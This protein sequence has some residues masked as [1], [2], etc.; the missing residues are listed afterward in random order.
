MCGNFMQFYC[1]ALQV[2]CSHFQCYENGTKRSIYKVL[3]N[4]IC[5]FRLIIKL[6]MTVL[7]RLSNIQKVNMIMVLYPYLLYSSFGI[8]TTSH[9]TWIILS[10]PLEY[11]S[12][13]FFL[14]ALI[15]LKFLK[16][17]DKIRFG[18]EKSFEKV[19]FKLQVATKCVL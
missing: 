2:F 16:S 4:V 14:F 15:M 3:E 12:Y 11:N 9:L 17:V 19:F 13:N 18:Q 6:K 1:I 7:S 8:L 10:S 5:N